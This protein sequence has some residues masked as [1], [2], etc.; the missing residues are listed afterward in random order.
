M[1]SEV[2]E[3]GVK[4]LVVVTATTTAEPCAYGLGVTSI[5]PSAVIRMIYIIIQ[6]QK[7]DEADAG[8]TIARGKGA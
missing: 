2:H 1:S 3:V 6:R 5:R 4:G 8:S 7:L